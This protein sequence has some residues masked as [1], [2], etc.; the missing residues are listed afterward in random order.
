MNRQHERIKAYIAERGSITQAEATEELGITKL[1]TRIGEMRRKGYA[2][3]I[4]MEKG[5]NRYGEP[6]HF[7]KY[8]RVKE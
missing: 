2:V 6:T 8:S 5:V 3:N 7:A 4:T 1:S